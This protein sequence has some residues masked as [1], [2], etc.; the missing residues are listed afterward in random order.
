MKR[1][2]RIGICLLCLLLAMSI[3]AGCK[4]NTEN[5]QTGTQKRPTDGEEVA[6]ETPEEQTAGPAAYDVVYVPSENDTTILAT[7]AETLAARLTALTGLTCRAKDVAHISS[8]PD[9]H[10]ILIGKV[11]AR[12]ESVNAYNSIAGT[13]YTISESGNK[14]CVVGSDHLCTI[15]A[16]QVFLDEYITDSATAPV[17]PVGQ[18]VKVD[19]RETVTVADAVNGG[20]LP[21]VYGSDSW[22]STEHADPYFRSLYGSSDMRSY[23]VKIAGK[24]FE[25]LKALT[26]GYDYQFEQKSDATA[27]AGGEFL[28]GITN[29]AVGRAFLSELKGNECGFFVGGGS[30][31]LASFSDIALSVAYDGLFNDLI[32]EASKVENGVYRLSFPDG[33]KVKKTYNENW[34]VDFPKPEG[35]GISLYN[36]MDDSEDCLQYLYR[37]EGVGHE[38]FD[39]YVSR[40]TQSGYTILTQNTMAENKFATLVNN[41]AGVM[42]SVAYDAFAHKGE[43]NYNENPVFDD[44]DEDNYDYNAM[45]QK[46]LRVVSCSTSNPKVTVPG[47]DVL[48]KPTSWNK[49]TDTSITAVEVMYV[50]YGYLIVLEDGRFIMLDGGGIPDSSKGGATAANSALYALMKSRYRAIYGTDP[51]EEQPIVIAAWVIT[52]SHG[53]H[54]GVPCSFLDTYGKSTVQ[55]QYL[56]GNWPASNAGYT[57]NGTDN[58]YMTKTGINRILTACPSARFLKVHTGQTYYFANIKI[59]VLMTPEDHNPFHI[60]NSND[61]NSVLRFCAYSSPTDDEPYKMIWL[62]DSN[63]QQSRWLCAMYGDFLRTDMVSLGHH[64]NVGCDIELYDTMQPTVAWFPHNSSVFNTYLSPTANTRPRRVDQAVFGK[65]V[66]GDIRPARTYLRYLFFSG[67]DT[68]GTDHIMLPF[69]NGR[70]DFENAVNLG[71]GNTITYRTT[72][73]TRDL[74]YKLW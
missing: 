61:A 29:R 53:D 73:T 14:I 31:A 25:R 48:T 26:A 2:T 60:D 19:N 7:M 27:A 34:V 17:A 20:L 56:V 37:G 51:T 52:H 28:V 42:L 62:G 24:V 72:R 21:I 63:R 30:V 35:E 32:K 4:K 44:D 55:L 57:L 16:L 58:G 13:G 64:G 65:S 1:S 74:A 23:P 70:P 36:T 22:A 18:A 49:V 50:G 38:A 41:A 45:Y 69:V 33:F 12:E 47:S 71:T 5:G 40:L 9:A 39:A 54:Y 10:E 59:D 8:D 67:N 6:P 3:L 43:Y 46:C 15:W 66:T 11:S 68:G